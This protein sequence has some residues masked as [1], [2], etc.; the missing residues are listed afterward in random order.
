MHRICHWFAKRL[1]LRMITCEG[2]PYL[3][4]F[5]VCGNAPLRY[6]PDGTKSRL[7]WLPFAVYLHGFVRH[8]KDRDLHNHPWDKSY[9]LILTA[10]YDE[11]RRDGDGI[12]SRHVRPGQI[13]VIAKNDYH[14]VTKLGADIVWTLFITG[15]KVDTWGFWDRDTGELV[16]WR[17][18]IARKEAV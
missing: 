5:Y 2:E 4:R 11:E 7:H 13:N 10:G 15:K 18:Y 16:P 14:R 1:P 3:M 17:E 6:W 8:D 9:S 12:V